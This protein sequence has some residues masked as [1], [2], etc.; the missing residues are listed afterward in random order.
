MLTCGLIFTFID[1]V[2]NDTKITMALTILYRFISMDKG[3]VLDGK[4]TKWEN[5]PV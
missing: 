1:Y 3:P 4:T 5:I 2:Y